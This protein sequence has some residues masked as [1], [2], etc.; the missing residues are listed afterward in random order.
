[1]VDNQSVPTPVQ[2]EMPATPEGEVV[3]PVEQKV[4]EPVVAQP[5]VAP[6]VVP[7]EE[8]PVVET[9]PTALPGEESVVTPG[10]EAAPVDTIVMDELPAAEEVSV[11]PVVEEVATEE[12][13]PAE[14]VEEVVEEVKDEVVEN[15]NEDSLPEK[16]SEND[17]NKEI[18]LVEEAPAE[19]VAEIAPEEVQPEPVVEEA[20]VESVEP[21][22]VEEVKEV[23]EEKKV[24]KIEKKSSSAKATED[25]SVEKKKKG[26]KEEKVKVP[27]KPQKSGAQIFIGFIA[28]LLGLIVIAYAFVLWALVEGNFTDPQFAQFLDMVGM[29]PTELKDKFTMITHILFG[30]LSFVFLIAALVKF[31][32]WVMTPADSF[33]KKSHIKKVGGYTVILFMFVGI[34]I[35]LIW[36]ISQAEANPPVASGKTDQLILTKPLNAVGLTAPITVDFDLGVLLFEKVPKELVREIYWD[37]NDDGDFSDASGPKVSH[38]FLDRGINNGRFPIHVVVTYF[39]PSVNA[40]KEYKETL[41]VIISN[42]AA[43]AKMTATPEAGSVP[44]TVKFSAAES[45]DADGSIIRYEWDMDANGEFD[46]EVGPNAVEVEKTFYQIGDHVVKVRITGANNDFAI[47]EKII[48]VVAAEEKVRAEITSPDS[49]FEGMIPLSI[50]FEGDQSYSREGKVVKYEW[51]VVGENRPFEGRTMQR[52]FELPGEY[53]VELIVENEGGD[54]D[55]VSQ[56]VTVYER[57]N[58]KIASAPAADEVDGILRGKVPFAVTFDS[59]QSEVP[60]AVEWQWDFEKDGIVDEYAKKID[61]TFRKAGTYEVMLTIVD[62]D[63][64]HFNVVQKVIVEDLGVVAKI[65]ATPP[66]GSVPLKVQFDGSG[67]QSSDGDIIDYIWEFPGEDPIHYSGKIDYEF[68]EV[69]VFPVKMTA[70]TSTGV[71]DTTE[72]MVSVR[73]Q[74][75]QASFTPTPLVGNV[76][77]DVKFSPSGSTGNIDTYYWE[78]GDGAVSTDAFPTHKFTY[79]GEFPVKLKITD[80][81]GIVSEITQKVTVKPKNKPKPA[82]E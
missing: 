51:Q 10:V 71:E 18:P 7:A 60:K 33:Y 46:D 47:A 41:D 16:P 35:G 11:E 67:S 3:A 9:P 56:I 57:R 69:G 36:L 38:R 12:A 26:A 4:E 6:E 32:Q 13:A 74:V 22:K 8:V 75:L 65:S 59:A 1:M 5:E 70:L 29:Q 54:R 21:E 79:P 63:D 19:I 20:V 24:E 68:K 39:S 50:T 28:I 43:N 64:S 17:D 40:E 27:T 66:S 48:S 23:V 25:A 34:W 72:I 37:F 2:P 62:A 44:L 81:R 30:G 31:F 76:P 78:F 14:T 15:S 49:A 73:G 42:V 61:Y 80:S 52:V 53:E 82:T 55:M 77:L 45:K 58:M